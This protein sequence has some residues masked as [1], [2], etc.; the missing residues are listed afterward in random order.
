MRFGLHLTTGLGLDAAIHLAVRAEEL[1]FSE[2]TY[3]DALLFR[4]PW[5]VLA[6]IARETRTV[7]LGPAVSN[8]FAQHPAVLAENARDLDEIS[9]GRALIGLG[10]GSHFDVIGLDPAQRLRSLEESVGVIRH[11]TEGLDGPFEG[12]VYRLSAKARLMF[13]APRRVPVYL[14]VFGPRATAM[15]GRVADGIRPPGQWDPTYMSSLRDQVAA[16]ARSVGRDPSVVRLVLQNWTCIDA[17]RE[18]ALA[19]ARPTLAVRLPS[20]GP[21]VEFYGIDGSEVAAARAAVQ[22]DRAALGGISDATVDRFMAVGDADDLAR[23]LD[24]IAAAGFSDVT[25]SGAL[26][27]DP[28]AALEI[29][30][31]ELADRSGGRR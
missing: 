11:L 27:P 22:G 14:G 9:G 19:A 7:H 4:P 25:F 16:G 13:G 15:A 6:L 28:Y 24:R 26:G 18:R 31:A 29:L 21:M 12:S 5:S 17:D 23:G 20:I 8:P 10:Q 30:G 2:V 1:G 3:H